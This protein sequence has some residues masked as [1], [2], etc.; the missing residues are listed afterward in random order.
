MIITPYFGTDYDTAQ[1]VEE[2]FHSGD[3]FLLQLDPGHPLLI[4]IDRSLYKIGTRLCIH[5]GESLK[6]A[7]FCVR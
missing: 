5:F 7:I 6:K 2:G 4:P 1:D 3:K